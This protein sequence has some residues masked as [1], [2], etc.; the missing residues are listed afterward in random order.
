MNQNN[1]I[2]LVHA[3]DTTMFVDNSGLKNCNE[4]KRLVHVEFCRANPIDRISL[5]N[6]SSLLKRR[7]GSHTDEFL[8]HGFELYEA[9]QL[10]EELSRSDRWVNI[11]LEKYEI[12]VLYAKE[13]IDFFNPVQWIKTASIVLDS[14]LEVTLILKGSPYPCLY[15]DPYQENIDDRE[16]F[17]FFDETSLKT[18]IKEMYYRLYYR[19]KEIIKNKS[20]LH[21]DHS[22]PF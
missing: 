16:L 6:R 22:D 7:G 4:F 15:P 17:E 12:D 19:F 10:I 21:S 1:F 5:L 8:N 14:G 2:Y 11:K 18:R 13:E 3:D 20:T 9:E